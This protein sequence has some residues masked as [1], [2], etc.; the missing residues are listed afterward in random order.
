MKRV[1]P[2]EVEINGGA[3]YHT[4]DYHQYSL[5]ESEDQDIKHSGSANLGIEI[6]HNIPSSPFDIGMM[7]YMSGTGYYDRSHS[8][9]DLRPF[10]TAL[11]SDYNFKQGYKLNPY[12]GMGVGWGRIDKLNGGFGDKDKYVSGYLRGGVELWSFL[13]VEMRAQISRKELSNI[14]LNIGFV[15][16]GWKS[17]KK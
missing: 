3:T 6:R 15:I 1:V 7:F 10:G 11:M 5:W 9:K 17:R 14:G 12:V 2:F 16:G 13:R 8:K 4:Y